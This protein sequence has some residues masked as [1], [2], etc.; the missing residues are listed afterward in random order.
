VATIGAI[1][2]N[3]DRKFHRHT[4]VRRFTDPEDEMSGA[5]EI[6]K[7]REEIRTVHHRKMCGGDRSNREISLK[8]NSLTGN[9]AIGTHIREQFEFALGEVR[10]HIST[11]HPFGT[12]VGRSEEVRVRRFADPE[13][14]KHLHF[15]IAKSGIPMRRKTLLWGPGDVTSS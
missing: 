13:D 2:K 14:R 15:R 4:K 6:A 5:F 11:S 10:G 7:S 12:R 8:E 1:R 9:S 3:L